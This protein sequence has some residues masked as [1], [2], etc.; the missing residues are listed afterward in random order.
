MSTNEIFK[1][2]YNKI[3]N[4]ENYEEEMNLVLT[5][6]VAASKEKNERKE[7]EIKLKETRGRIW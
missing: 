5:A 3:L 4:D 7:K 2:L 6:A 1:D